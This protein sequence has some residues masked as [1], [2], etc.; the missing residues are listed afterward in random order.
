MNHAEVV[1]YRRRL[2]AGL[3]PEGDVASPEAPEAPKEVKSAKKSSK[4]SQK[5]APEAPEGDPV[6]NPDSDDAPVDQDKNE[7][8]PN[9]QDELAE[10]AKLHAERAWINPKKKDRYYELRAKFKK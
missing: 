5:K 6:Q 10:F 4:S 3:P 2:A 7:P 8:D 1:E 9:E